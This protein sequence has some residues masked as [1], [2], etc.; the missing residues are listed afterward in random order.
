MEREPR[1]QSLRRVLTGAV[2]IFF[3]IFKQGFIEG[4]RADDVLSAG[5]VAEIEHAATRAA[6]WKLGVVF[7][8]HRLLADGAA[9]LHPMSIPQTAPGAASAC[10]RMQPV[11]HRR[12]CGPRWKRPG[13]TPGAPSPDTP[14][15]ARIETRDARDR[16]TRRDNTAATARRLSPRWSRPSGTST[17]PLPT[18]SVRRAAG[19]SPASGLLPAKT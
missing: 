7:R 18:T 5:P 2:E 8:I 12:R 15:C 6:E 11:R 17:R 19:S 10:F 1:R 4:G 3:Q 16:S 9:R 13:R 14:R